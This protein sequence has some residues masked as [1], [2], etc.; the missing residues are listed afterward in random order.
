MVI[1][2]GH[3]AEWLLGE[4]CGMMDIGRL[5]GLVIEEWGGFMDFGMKKGEGPRGRI[6]LLVGRRSFSLVFVRT[7]GGRGGSFLVS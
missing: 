6:F 1:G 4:R 3:V 5:F 2:A 7:V